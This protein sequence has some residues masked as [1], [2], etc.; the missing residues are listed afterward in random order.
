VPDD[1]EDPAA[2]LLPKCYT[3]VIDGCELYEQSMDPLFELYEFFYP[4][5]GVE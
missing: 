5:I 2:T 4:I 3:W 1:S